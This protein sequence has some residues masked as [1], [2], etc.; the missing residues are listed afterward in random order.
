MRDMQKIK[1]SKTAEERIDDFMTE[2]LYMNPMQLKK[3]QPVAKIKNK[4]LFEVGKITN[5]R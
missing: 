4:S 3:Q 2:L 1:I 5:K